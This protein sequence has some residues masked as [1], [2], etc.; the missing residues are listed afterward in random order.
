M[1][2][3]PSRES[4]LHC[5]LSAEGN[6][7]VTRLRRKLGWPNGDRMTWSIRLVRRGKVGV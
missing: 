1:K 3:M 6:T 4:K 7:C 2:E 5:S